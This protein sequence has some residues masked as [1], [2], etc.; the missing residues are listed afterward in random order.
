MDRYEAINKTVDIGTSINEHTQAW[1]WFKD[2]NIPIEFD[3]S[4]TTGA[5]TSQTSNNIGVF[6]ITLN[7]TTVNL[8]Y[9]CRIRFLD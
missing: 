3:N 1:S 8:A 7:S 9:T 2:V 6:G 4:A 5:L